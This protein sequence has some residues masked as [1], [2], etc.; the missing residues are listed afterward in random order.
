MPFLGQRL[1]ENFTHR[2]LFGDLRH[3]QPGSLICRNCFN[4]L[5]TGSKSNFKYA[6]PS[7]VYTAFTKPD[8][9][10]LLLAILKI[11]LMSIKNLWSNL[12][13]S[14][15]CEENWQTFRTDIVRDITLSCKQY[16]RDEAKYETHT[17]AN[18]LNREY[19]PNIRCPVGCFMFINEEFYNIELHYL[20]CVVENFTYFGA[21]AKKN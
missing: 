10:E 5:T 17:L 8:A 20:A 14:E 6:W 4:H 13:K 3:T 9:G 16:L 19:F 1:P 11:L 12:T 21:E 7:I 15:Q 18:A 2:R